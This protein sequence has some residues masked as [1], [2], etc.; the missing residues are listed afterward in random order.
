MIIIEIIGDSRNPTDVITNKQNL[1]NLTSSL[2]LELESVFT[3][4]SLV[5]N[6]I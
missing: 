2:G 5:T 4:V 6:R 3:E 1:F